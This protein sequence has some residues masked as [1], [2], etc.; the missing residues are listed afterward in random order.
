LTK[1]IVDEPG[2][3]IEKARRFACQEILDEL[4]PPLFQGQGRIGVEVVGRGLGHI[5][6]L[7]VYSTGIKYSNARAI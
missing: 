5:Q 7:C 1:I 2:V 4:C 6:I 3:I